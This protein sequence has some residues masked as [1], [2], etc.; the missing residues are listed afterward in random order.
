[1][2]RTIVALVFALLG[3]LPVAGDSLGVPQDALII[4]A[5]DGAGPWG[6]PDGTGCGNDIVLAAYAAVKVPARLE[7]MPYSRAK[8]GV[9]AGH[10]VACFGM[11]WTE[12]LKGKVVFADKPLYSVTAMLVQSLSKPL[13]AVSIKELTIGTRVGTVFEYEYPATFYD[14]AKRGI[15][16]PM[17]AYSEVV[18][19]KNLELGRVDAALVVID[20]LKSLDYLIAQAGLEGKVGPAF[21]LGGQGTYLGFSITHPKSGF[22]RQ[23]FN[24]GFELITKDGTL[25]RI[26]ETWRGKRP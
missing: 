7:V 16:S 10:Y 4:A 23:Q 5:E 14:L 11:A 8:S 9:L 13:G 26:L 17:P 25:K 24:K 15:L 18:S 6:Q 2:F 1:M 19:L 21:G 12:D 22:A 20:E 3:V